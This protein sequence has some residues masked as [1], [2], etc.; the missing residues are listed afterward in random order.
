M[1]N[2]SKEFSDRI[3]DLRNEILQSIKSIFIEHNLTELDISDAG[4]RTYVIWWDN[5]NFSNE[6]AVSTVYYDGTEISLE[7][8][9]DDS[10]IRVYESD[11]ALENPIW[12]NSVRDNILETLN[13]I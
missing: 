8:E 1:D 10:P 13:S 6:G 11:Y 9:T 2:K 4:D 12:L 7:V 5:D 3:F